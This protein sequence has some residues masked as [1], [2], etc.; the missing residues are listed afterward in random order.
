MLSGNLGQDL[1]SGKRRFATGLCSGA[2]MRLST[3]C[4]INVA[5]RAYSTKSA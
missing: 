3:I 4:Y 2:E 1:A 5:M